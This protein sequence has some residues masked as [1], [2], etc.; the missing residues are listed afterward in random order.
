[1][2]RYY[3]DLRMESAESTERARNRGGDLAPIVARREALDREERLRIAELRQKATLRIQ[4]RLS[5]LLL[6]HQPKLRLETVVTGPRGLAVPLELIWDPLA[7]AL[8]AVVCP[9]CGAPTFTLGY[10]PPNRLTCPSC[11]SSRVAGR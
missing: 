10:A 4:L 3:S 5:N 2:A 8:E 9:A 11:P 7:E 1:M 6:V